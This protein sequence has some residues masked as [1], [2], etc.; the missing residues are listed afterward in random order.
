[1]ADL[2]SDRALENHALLVMNALD[3][4]IAN[5]DDPDYMIDSLLKT[6]KSHQRFENFSP[7]IFWAIEEPFL[8]AVKQTLGD[9]MSKS[10]ERIYAKAIR[11]VLSTL[12]LG[13]TN[14]EI[15]VKH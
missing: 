15:H 4:S 2:Y 12:I 6:G 1:M 9:K 14:P 3:E 10:L 8:N 5:M 7:N 13:I 11:F